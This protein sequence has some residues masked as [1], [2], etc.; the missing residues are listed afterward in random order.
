MIKGIF[1]ESGAF[2]KILQLIVVLIF[3]LLFTLLIVGLATNND[4]SDIRNLKIMQLIQSVGMFVVPPLT[5]AFLWSE[6][7]LHYLQ[8]TTKLKLSSILLVVVLMIVAIPFIN[9]ITLLNQQMALPDFLAPVETWMKNSEA[10]AA[11][12]T[13]KMLNIHSIDGLLFNI[14]LIAMIPA[15]GEEL[16][17]RGTIQKLLTEWRSAIAGIWIA[18]FVFSAIH[19]QF[20]GFF[21]RMLLGAFFG[22]LLVWSGSLWLPIIAHFTNNAIAVIFY[23]LKYNDYQVVDIDVIGSGETLWLGIVGGV[24]TVGGIILIKKNLKSQEKGL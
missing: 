15:L 20:Y 23:Y 14:L 2:S 11:A 10:Q 4:M 16:F 18:A 9:L 13:E 8:L 5:L 21:P 17:F 1:K 12:L 22:Y 7:P 24:L 19:L 6:K 3:V